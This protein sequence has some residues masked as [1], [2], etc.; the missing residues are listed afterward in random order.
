MDIFSLGLMI[1]EIITGHHLFSQMLYKRDKFRNFFKAPPPQLSTALEQA[2]S[3]CDIFTALPNKVHPAARLP[4]QPINT[5]HSYCFQ[6]LMEACLSQSP[7]QRPSAKAISVTLGACPASLPQRSFFI[8][9]P[10]KKAFLGSCDNFGEL[11]IG[12][13]P[14]KWELFTITPGKWNFQY[15]PI[16]HPD[17]TIASI[18]YL[19]K[20]VWIA[21]E[22]SRRI[23]CLSLPDLEGGHM[24]WS[25][26]AE[27]PV[28]MMS[29]CLHDDTAILVG[30]MGG[31]AAIFDDFVARHLLDSMPTFVDIAV[32]IEDRDPVVC[33]CAHKGWVW[34]GCNRHLVA[35]DPAEHTIVR[36]S[37][38]SEEQAVSHVVSSGDVMWATLQNS[39]QLIKCLV[40][41]N[42]TLHHKYVVIS[43]AYTK[44]Y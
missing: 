11:I 28:F 16:L 37:L 34:L 2:L 22:Q 5:C 41:A 36:T 14:N 19:N 26:L 29:Y 7:D 21:T 10:I 44:D 13:S 39:S 25:A 3:N 40:T 30:M 33:G 42:G 20:E 9:T 15:Y 35:V 31:V 38:L 1:H 4:N 8:G 6:K 12:F 43:L 17:D 24:S 32:D 27:K 23:Y 18:A